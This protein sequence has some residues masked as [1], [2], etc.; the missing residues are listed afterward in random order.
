MV[1]SYV[2]EKS[3]TPLNLVFFVMDRHTDVE[4]DSMGGPRQHP[5]PGSRWGDERPEDSDNQRN[6]RQTG[7]AGIHI[8][9]TITSPP[10]ETTLIPSQCQ[11]KHV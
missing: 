9:V 5:P 1:V 3:C 8:P 7:Q 2:K 11:A 4:G 10:G 6:V